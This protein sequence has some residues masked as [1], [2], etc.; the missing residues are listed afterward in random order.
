MAADAFVALT[1]R[2]YPATRHPPTPYTDE[3]GATVCERVAQGETLTAITRDLQLG[4]RTLW[5]WRVQ[6]PEFGEALEIAQEYAADVDVERMHDLCLQAIAQHPKLPA[7]ALK[8]LMAVGPI[9]KN[10]EWR[11]AA[12][13]RRKYG[14][15]PDSGM[16]GGLTLQINTAW[17]GKTV[18]GD[19]VSVV[20]D[21]P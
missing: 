15:R 1:G 5:I 4:N 17:P 21:S 10:L 18:D 20:D 2:N 16:S 6:Y 19:A 8:R 7:L 9:L 12:K 13:N 11:A 14:P 3:L